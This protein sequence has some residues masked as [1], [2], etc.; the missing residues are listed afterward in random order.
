MRNEK[1]QTEG[2]ILEEYDKSE[3]DKL[4]KIFTKDFGVIFVLGKSIRQ[5]KSKMRMHMVKG[6]VI[7]FSFIAGKEVKRLVGVTDSSHSNTFK[8]VAPLLSRFIHGDVPHNDLYLRFKDF[9]KYPKLQFDNMIYAYIT[10][11][12]LGYADAC[13]IGKGSIEE[14]R[15][16]SI[17][18][19][20]SMYVIRQ[21][22]IKKHIDNVKEH[23]HL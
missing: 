18:E 22:E 16:M 1:V 6:R 13:E 9:D 5:T 2:V 15:S 19:L 3:H 17:D 11:V 7:N 20:V 14:M 4:Y 21:G 12:E 8:Q 23:L 10:L